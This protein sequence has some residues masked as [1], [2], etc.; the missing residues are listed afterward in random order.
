MPSPATKPLQDGRQLAALAN[1]SNKSALRARIMRVSHVVIDGNSQITFL[2]RMESKV[3]SLLP[4][5]ERTTFVAT[6]S[7]EAPI[8]SAVEASLLKTGD[9]VEFTVHPE[10]NC[11]D[12]VKV[13]HYSLW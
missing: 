7:K 1:D 4:S 9:E 13:L 10:S 2:M 5:E 8:S 3:F 12:Q 6:F 11:I